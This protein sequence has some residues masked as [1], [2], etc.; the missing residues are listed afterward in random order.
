MPKIIVDLSRLKIDPGEYMVTHVST[1]HALSGNIR[2]TFETLDGIRV[3]WYYRPTLKNF[4]RMNTYQ[5]LLAREEYYLLVA[6]NNFKII[7]A[8]YIEKRTRIQLIRRRL[9]DL[10][11]RLLEQE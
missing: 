2:Q 9:W 4:I 5:L 1:D 3:Y 7:T 8:L 6:V 10:K 11:R